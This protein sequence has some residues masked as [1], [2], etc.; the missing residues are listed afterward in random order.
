MPK[1]DAAAKDK[2]AAQALSNPRLN[3]QQV[4]QVYYFSHKPL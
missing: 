2:P 4:R 3:K 1:A